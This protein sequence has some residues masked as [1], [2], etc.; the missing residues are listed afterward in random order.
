MAAVGFS[1]TQ[2]LCLG[3]SL[4]RVPR[5]TWDMF[6]LRVIGGL[7]TRTSGSVIFRVQDGA[8]TTPER[9]LFSG[10][11]RSMS[12][13]RHQRVTWVTGTMRRLPPRRGFGIRVQ[14]RR[15]RGFVGS[16]R[17]LALINQV[18][19]GTRFKTPEA[20][21]IGMADPADAM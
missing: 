16:I 4:L 20:L 17:R 1:G 7:G 5:V 19:P 18:C 10:S 14:L 6:S 15:P 3:W 12:P 8:A 2:A 13:I 9:P 21:R 11:A